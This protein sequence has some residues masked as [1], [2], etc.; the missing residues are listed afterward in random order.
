VDSP[1]LDIT[2]TVFDNG[3]TLLTLEKHD[4]PIVTSTIWYNV[5]S[6]HECKGHTGISHLLEHLMFKGTHTYAKGEIDFLTS[7]HGGNSN[8]GTIYDY[9]LYHFNF[10]SDR[11]EI[12][13]EIEA[14]RMR[15]C[16]FESDEF[17]SERRVVLEELKQ[18]QDSPWGK[19]GMQLEATM[20]QEHPYHHTPIGFQE[21]LEHVSRDAVIAYYNTYY[22]PN[23]AT[24]VIV[25]DISTQ[26]AIQKV[27][28]LFAHIPR[29][30]DIPALIA[31]EPKQHR[32]QRFELIQNTT[33]KRL[34]IGYHAVTLPDQDNYP[35]EIVDY[36]LSH[37]KTSRF[38]QRLVEQDQ[39]V[40]FVDTYNYPRRLPGVFY[41][42]AE[43]RPGIS[44]EA[45]EHALTEE[46]FRLQTEKISSEEFQKVQNVIA[47]DFTFEKETTAGLAHA[48]GEY[49]VLYTH[50]YLNSYLEHIA[51]VTPEE[52]LRVATTYFTE[53]NRT[54]GW[55]L[56]DSP[57]KESHMSTVFNVPSVPPLTDMV[58]HKPLN[59]RTFQSHRWTLDN[60]LTVLFLENHVLPV[61]SIEVFVAAGQVYEP[62]E[63]AGMAVLT[64]RL[65]EEGTVHRSAFEIAQAIEFVGGSLH[66]TSRG[67]S[68]Q[69]LSKD[70][71]LGLDIV[72]DILIHPVFEQDTLEKE[73]RRLLGML[74]SDEDNPS[75][76]AHNLFHEMVYGTHPYHR[77]RKGYKE[78]VQKLTQADILEYYTTYFVPNNTILAIVGDVTSAEV[79]EQVHRYFRE[80]AR[81]DLPPEPRFTI[82]RSDGCVT[83]HIYREKEQSHL[84]LGHLGITRTNPD[85]YA[86]LTM[87]HI[88]GTGPGF[89]DRISRKLR[90]EQGLAYTVYANITLSAEAEPGTFMA[91]IG[92]SPENMKSAVQGFLDEIKKIRTERVSLEEL[93]LAKN[94]LTGS[95]VFYFE[96][97]TQLAHYL[98]HTERFDLGDDFLWKY[99]QLIHTVTIDDIYRVARQYLDPENY[100]VA[101][102]GTIPR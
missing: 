50:E 34:Q 81:R 94:Y 36:I 74:D 68:A 38:Y 79:I 41:I 54:V 25:G 96:T 52:V 82:P 95:Y 5:G 40:T 10:S 76:V 56:P 58:F 75:L 80:W 19:L 29:G 89:T 65:L 86:L 59:S 90:D 13:L 30:K 39:L 91:Y 88:L 18:L 17:E 3:L 51:Q 43:L 24:I 98:I 99:P 44:Q 45:V 63:K 69:V 64:G 27:H 4:V 31:A 16:L 48:L 7:T 11:W 15:N 71:V 26:T 55:S 61:V 12:A 53:A 97:S 2:K 42:F 33:L 22:V 6:A 93:E 70:F 87:D 101:T 57:E 46:I 37:G 100:Y 8:A 14:D 78:T 47:A 60:G 32:E 72:S 20:F 23:N 9:T 35:L 28:Q 77:P 83:K 49:E 21:D 92:T 66:T 85:Y 84:Y 73:R 1:K 102:V 67:V 62:D